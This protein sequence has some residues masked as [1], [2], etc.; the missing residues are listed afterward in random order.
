VKEAVKDEVKSPFGFGFATGEDNLLMVSLGTGVWRKEPEGLLRNLAAHKALHALTTMIDDASQLAITTVQAFAR[1][2]IPSNINFELED[3]KGLGIGKPLLSY[4][5]IDTKLETGS[6]LALVGD[7]ELLKARGQA[8]KKPRK[9]KA[10][11]RV[12][13]SELKKAI[14]A[15]R[16]MDN[17]DK[18]NLD[19]L[20]AMGEKLGDAYFGTAELADTAIPRKFDPW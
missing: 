10:H 11:E 13:K 16:L 4:L 14:K 7:Q 15:V 5:R 19:L 12:V 20:K 3:M 18:R 1:P 6:M 2:T 8:R 9:A 17:P